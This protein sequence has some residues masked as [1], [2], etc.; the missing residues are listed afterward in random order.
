MAIDSTKAGIINSSN[1]AA[2]KVALGTEVKG[3]EDRLAIAEAAVTALQ[4]TVAGL[5][6]GVGITLPTTEPA[7]AGELWSN[8]LVVTVSDGA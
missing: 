4:A 5:I 6:T 3:L 7:T 2:Q 8:T 1:P